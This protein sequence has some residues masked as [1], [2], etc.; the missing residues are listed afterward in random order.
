[1]S[2]PLQSL[3]MLCALIIVST[4]ARAQSTDYV[5]YY[6]IFPSDSV[7]VSLPRYDNSFFYTK[8]A[9]HG[10]T[11]Q[12]LSTNDEFIIRYK[13]YSGHFGLDTFQVVYFYPNPNTGELAKKSKKV[14]IKTS[15][16]ILNPDDYTLYTTDQNIELNVLSNDNI[17]GGGGLITN[18]PIKGNAQLAINS[19]SSKIIFQ[20]CNHAMSEQITYQVT[21]NGQKE[22]GIIRINVLDTTSTPQTL[23]FYK[24][25]VKNNPISFSHPYQYLNTVHNTA[26]GSITHNGFEWTYTP[27]T[28]YIGTDTLQIEVGTSGNSAVHQFLFKIIDAS[29]ANVLVNNDYFYSLKSQNVVCNVLENDFDM[30]LYVTIEAQP[31]NGTLVKMANGIYKYI[32]NQGFE[33]VDLF[34][35]KACDLASNVCEYGTATI[36]V[37]NFEPDNVYHLYAAKG[38]PFKIYYPFPASGYKVSVINSAYP[39]HALVYSVD[40][41]RNLEYSPSQDYVG[42]DSM[43]IKYTLIVNPS[44]YYIVKVYIHTYDTDPSCYS[45][46]VWPGDHNNDGRVD[47]RDLTFIAPFIGQSGSPRSNPQNDYWVGQSA[48]DWDISKDNTNLKYGDGDGDGIILAEDTLMMNTYYRNLHGI[49]VSKGVNSS[50][51]PFDLRSDKASYEP[52]DSITMTLSI[53]DETLPVP[54][55]AGFTVSFNFSEAFN[56]S[57]LSAKFINNNWLESGDKVLQMAKKPIAR[58]IDLGAGRLS[59]KGVPGYGDIAVIKGIVDDELDGFKDN[60]GTYYARIQL[61]EATLLQGDGVELRTAPQ[62]FYFPIHITKGQVNKADK[63][64]KVYPNPSTGKIWLQSTNTDNMIQSYSVYSISGQL[65]GSKEKINQ[66]KIEINLEKYP[67]GVYLVKTFTLLGVEVKKVEKL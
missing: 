9:K 13:P 8:I 66:N 31:D 20:G 7:I 28:D 32:P 40:N 33:G 53:G 67:A 58:N 11:D 38:S 65:L 26:H 48:D 39:K 45:Y 29:P 23:S 47:M 17:P 46:C 4:F 52:G 62:T 60:N 63:S 5:D 43:K 2:K 50:Y 61:N 55:L 3:Y 34:V 14:V 22:L 64:V 16:F 21:K 41:Q 36:T 10:T 42:L 6:N 24:F 54:D 59:G 18:L 49:W 12:L 44:I 56:D 1:M 51:L 37:S 27:D 35:Y 57:S 15:G 25:L 30:V 19:D